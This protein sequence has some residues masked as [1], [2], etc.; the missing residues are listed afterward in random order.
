MTQMAAELV[1]ERT[2]KLT[3]V[4]EM[5]QIWMKRDMN[6]EERKKEKELITEAQAKNRERMEE[7]V[8]FKTFLCIQQ[9]REDG[10]QV[11]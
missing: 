5:K 4:E 10:R 8:C 9:H 7:Y 3:K 2:G 11:I 1:I 6:K